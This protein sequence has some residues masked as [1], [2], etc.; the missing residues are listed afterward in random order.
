MHLI[1]LSLI[2]NQSIGIFKCTNYTEITTII[3]NESFQLQTK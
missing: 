3:D 1:D 2:Y